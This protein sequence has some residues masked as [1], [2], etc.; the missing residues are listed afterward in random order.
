MWLG[1]LPVTGRGFVH[2]EFSLIMSGEIGKIMIHFTHGELM[3]TEL[4]YVIQGECG[5]DGNSS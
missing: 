2:W 3:D 1:L 4:K 5:R